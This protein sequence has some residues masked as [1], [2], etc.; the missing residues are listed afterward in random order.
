MENLLELP[1]SQKLLEIVTKKLKA[2]DSET[3]T[4]IVFHSCLQQLENS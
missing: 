1:W 4:A 3:Q 2:K